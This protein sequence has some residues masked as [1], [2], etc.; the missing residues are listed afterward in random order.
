M[1]YASGE[2]AWWVASE[3]SKEGGQTHEPRPT[4]TTTPTIATINWWLTENQKEDNQLNIC[5]FERILSTFSGVS[6]YFHFD[7]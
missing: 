2:V 3:Q 1:R 7:H 4:T 5:W 6:G